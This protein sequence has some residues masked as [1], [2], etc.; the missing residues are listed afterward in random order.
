[1]HLVVGRM[2]GVALVTTK[3]LERWTPVHCSHLAE[4]PTAICNW[5]IGAEGRAVKRSSWIL[6]L[7]ASIVAILAL[8]AFDFYRQ[9]NLRHVRPAEIQ[10]LLTHETVLKP[11]WLLRIDRARPITRWHYRIPRDE[12][13]K[14]KAK[15]ISGPSTG[16]SD[17]RREAQ[18]PQCMI[19]RGIDRAGSSYM[20]IELISSEAVISEVSM[21]RE[22]AEEIGKTLR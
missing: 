17:Q 5:V 22:E 18:Q 12:L 16:P 10:L 14:L 7:M 8:I 21:S 13:A 11:A 20:V 9:W 1:M 3:P 2:L 15:C 4:M 19:A 6:L